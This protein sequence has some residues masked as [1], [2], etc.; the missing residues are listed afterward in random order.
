[1]PNDLS[2]YRDMAAH[3][4]TLVDVRTPAEFEDAHATGAI[5]VPLDQLDPATV[6]KGFPPDAVVHLICQSGSRASK[7]CELFAA[8]GYNHVTVVPGGTK[9]WIECGLPVT[10]GRPAMSLERQVRIAA[11][12]LVL[13]GVVLGTWVNPWCYV[14]SGF[15]GA[16]LMFAGVTE[17]CG[18]GML[19]AK[20]PW[21]RRGGS[22][23]DS[24]C[25]ADP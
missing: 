3:G 1:M 8:A 2:H 23:A 13:G 18:M 17:F 6:M 9:A 5:S 21:N 15:V 22:S 16:G 7:A 19:L 10:R 4:I 25:G 24:C 11:G 12:A 14:L 20:M